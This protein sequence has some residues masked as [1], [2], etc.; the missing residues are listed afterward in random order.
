MLPVVLVRVLQRKRIG[1]MCVC[2]NGELGRGRE[3]ERDKESEREVYYEEL[4]YLIME[5]LRSM[6][7]HL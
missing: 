6:I 3:M 7:F 4:A 2:I 5:T 1:E